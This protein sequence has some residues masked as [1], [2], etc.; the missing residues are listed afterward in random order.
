MLVGG[1]TVDIVIYMWQNT[2]PTNMVSKA[3]L[4]TEGFYLEYVFICPFI[5]SPIK[6]LSNESEGFKVKFLDCIDDVEKK[7]LPWPTDHMT[8]SAGIAQHVTSG[9]SKTHLQII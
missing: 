2:N 3:Q 9:N 5:C 8:C 1:T 4:S 7:K 6:Y